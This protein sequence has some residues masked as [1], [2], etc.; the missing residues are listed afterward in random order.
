MHQFWLARYGSETIVNEAAAD[1]ET[2]IA[3]SGTDSAVERGNSIRFP[4]IGIFLILL[5]AALYLAREF[6]LPITLAFILALTLSPVVRFFKRRRIPPAFTAALLVI[7][8]GAV[9]LLAVYAMAVPVTDW[10]NRAPEIGNEL[11][12]KLADLKT[13]FKALL[14]AQKEV[15]AATTPGVSEVQK[16]TVQG[17]GIFASAATGFLAAVTTLI[18]T[19]VLLTFLLA[20]GDLFYAKL[21]QT[22]DTMKDKKR[23]LRIAHD[24]ER[25]VSRYLFTITII[26]ICLGIVI[27]LGLHALGMPTP[28]IWGAVAA[29]A[30][31]MPYIG[32]ILGLGAATAVAIV[33]F[34]TLAPAFYVAAFYFACTFIEGQFITPLIVGRRL[35]LNAVAVFVSV[36]FWA[37]LWGIVGALIAVPIL[38]ILKI[39]CD[40][41]PEMETLG[42]FLGAGDNGNAGD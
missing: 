17:P 40:H 7:A 27:A 19:M 6:F 4:V 39:V 12:Y 22:F 9:G 20:S 38:V 21:V 24:V 36:A 32:A 2:E 37:F 14:E 15:E 23:A 25:V 8:L 26:N 35:E 34:D 28:Y 29:L 10:I 11:K 31:F 33:S 3:E 42:N 16:V 13:P 18:V 30:N 5:L 1:P 41:F